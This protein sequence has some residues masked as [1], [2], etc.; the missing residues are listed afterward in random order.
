MPVPLWRTE[1]N[2]VSSMLTMTKGRLQSETSM[3]YRNHLKYNVT[4][5]DNSGDCKTPSDHG[6]PLESCAIG[7]CETRIWMRG[8]ATLL[9]RD[10]DG[11]KILYWDR[12]RTDDLGSDGSLTELTADAEGAD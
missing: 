2:A 12:L 11:W 10:G 9:S 1:A 7:R 4:W 3:T 6:G 5:T 8:S